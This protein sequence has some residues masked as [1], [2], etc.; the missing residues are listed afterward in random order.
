[1]MTREEKIRHCDEMVIRTLNQRRY[2]ETSRY[3][4]EDMIWRGPHGWGTVRGIDNFIKNVIGPQG[5]AF[6]DY[7][8]NNVMWIVEGDYVSTRGYFT[9]THSDTFLG[10]PASGKVVTV[11]FSDFWRFE[12]EKLAEN[13]VEVDNYGFLKQ[14][15]AVHGQAH[16]SDTT[17]FDLNLVARPN[18]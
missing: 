16:L 5:R 11:G 2:H 15:G 12:G 10:I 9:G 18:G 8:A 17:P 13:W 3:W 4:H 1:M 7:E 6:P 14:V